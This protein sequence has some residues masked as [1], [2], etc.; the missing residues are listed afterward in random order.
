MSTVIIDLTPAGTISKGFGPEA[1]TSQATGA[2]HLCGLIIWLLNQE[3]QRGRPPLPLLIVCPECSRA[4]WTTRGLSQHRRRA[5]PTEY[6]TQ[7][8]PVARQKT[9]WDHEELLILACAE[10]VFQRSGVRN[11][12]KRLAQITPGRTLEAIKG[13]RKSK[14]YQELLASLEQQEAD[15]S[16]PIER[17]ASPSEGA[18]VDMPEDPTPAPPEQPAPP[19]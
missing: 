6:H 7:N 16:E 17:S 5:H 1:K 13:V 9:C 2:N 11:V 15:S 4:F 10:I 14:R 19:G 8:V 18:P 12:N 3:K